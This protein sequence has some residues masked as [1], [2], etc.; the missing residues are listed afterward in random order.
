[1]EPLGGPMGPP[2]PMCGGM[3]PIMC[4][5]MEP[6]GPPRGGMLSWGPA[7]AAGCIIC[8]DGPP[9]PRTGRS[10]GQG[11]QNSSQDRTP[12]PWW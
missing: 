12:S 2:R 1:M 11:Q 3:P 10:T 4:G 9:T 8:W 6:G 5:G 7:R